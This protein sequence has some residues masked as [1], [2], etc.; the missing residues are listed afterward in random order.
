MSNRQLPLV[1]DV[2]LVCAC[3]LGLS[4]CPA[5]L[6]R[7]SLY[8]DLPTMPKWQIGQTSTAGPELGASDYVPLDAAKKVVLLDVPG[9]GQVVRIWL[10][11][12]TKDEQWG[13]ALVL[14]AY[15]DGEQSPSVQ[16]PL[17]DFFTGPFGE[18]HDNPNLL[19]GMAS[20]GYYCSAPMPFAAHARI[21]VQ[22][23]STL[24]I[25][26]FFYQVSYQKLAG[27]PPDTLY[28]HSAWR[29]SNPVPQGSSFTVA[30]VKGK[31][32][33]L[34]CSVSL[35]GFAS[36][37]GFLE[38]DEAFYIDDLSKPAFVG[39]GVED[40]FNCAW[41][42]KGG[43]I[44]AP[45]HGCTMKDDANTR[46]GAYR[47]HLDDAPAFQSYF[48]MT[49]GHG[50]SNQERADYSAVSYWYQQ[51]PHAPP[52]DL[53]SFD[54][55]VPPPP[56]RPPAVAQEGKAAAILERIKKEEQARKPWRL[57][58]PII[59]GAAGIIL[60]GFLLRALLRPRSR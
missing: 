39:T 44:T 6:A 37:P 42:F 13:R 35:R 60:I 31:G 32:R 51:E 2:A 53:P 30:E 17:R 43:P 14:R 54:K 48:R 56:S 38:G 20:Q 41:Y 16:A 50:E 40:Y 4:L 7:A 28:F 49:L 23:D 25:P 33:F 29:R 21:E 34:G 15:W 55:R 11:V 1:L 12:A 57:A 18:Y 58:L 10:T 24:S 52:P 22:N 46:Y 59:A 19:I 36:E 26:K 9:P 47:F 3:L 5:A 27:L 45:L 8:S